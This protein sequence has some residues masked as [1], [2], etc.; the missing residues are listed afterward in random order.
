MPN[1]GLAPLHKTF[2]FTLRLCLP[3]F[4]PYIFLLEIID[5]YLTV[6]VP[7]LSVYVW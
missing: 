1:G 6:L 2:T 7:L 4:Y 5:E 3:A